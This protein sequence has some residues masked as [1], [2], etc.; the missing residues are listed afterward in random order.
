MQLQKSTYLFVLPWNL[1]FAGG[2]NQVVINLAKEMKNS[3]VSEPLILICDWIAKKPVWGESD[4]LRTIRWR[5]RPFHPYMSIKE[6]IAYWVWERSFRPAFEK[7]SAMQRIEVINPHYPG[8]TSFSLERIARSLRSSPKL[9]FSFHGT[10]VNNH[11]E[12]SNDIKLAWKKLLLRSN[13]A[14]ACSHDLGNRIRQ[15]FGMEINPKVIHNGID[16]QGF[17]S[18]SGNAKKIG[19]RIIL[20]VGKFDHVKGQD[21]LVKAFSLISRNYPDASLVFV[22]ATGPALPELRELCI[23]EGVG[24]RVSFHQ[25][26]PHSEI[27]KF[28][29]QATMFVLPSR[30]EAFPIVILEA[31]SFG[32]PII[33]SRVGGIPEILIDDNNGMLV[34]SDMPDELAYRIRLTLD[35][36]SQAQEMG[37]RLQELVQ[38]NFTWASACKK[39]CNLIPQKVEKERMLESSD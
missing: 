36:P 35:N 1:E 29:C 17:V 18:K 7:F 16:A 22:G 14:V 38:S 32:L 28:F 10:D 37:N 30:R 24:N 34:S 13:G 23:N 33:A 12:S 6:K 3:G 39:Y 31:G 5:I 27:P 2:V 15:V 9:I 4:G 19:S 26:V 8:N 25:D 21:I 20:N 11:I